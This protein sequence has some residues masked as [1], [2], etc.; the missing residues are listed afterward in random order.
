MEPREPLEYLK[1]LLEDVTFAVESE[2]SVATHNPSD[3][4]NLKH[5]I[6]TLKH[7]QE[8]IHMYKVV[9][10]LLKDERKKVKH[11]FPLENTAGYGQLCDK[12]VAYDNVLGE[13][14]R[15]L[16]GYAEN[17]GDKRFIESVEKAKK[18]HLNS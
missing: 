11:I 14:E 17:T 5:V 18:F 13:I 3:I 9:D 10:E 1:E 8:I 7:Q 4:V 12:V 6:E 2:D 15:A 16:A